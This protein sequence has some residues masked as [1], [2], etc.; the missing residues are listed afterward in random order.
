MNN[1]Y[2]ILVGGQHRTACKG[3]SGGGLMYQYPDSKKMYIMGKWNSYSLTHVVYKKL[4][5]ISGIL[6]SSGYHPD[7]DLTGQ[8]DEF[9]MM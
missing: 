9:F 3:D 5:F 7:C 6:L 8:N 1:I 4:Y 2:F